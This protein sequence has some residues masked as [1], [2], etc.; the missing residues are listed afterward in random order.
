MYISCIDVLIWN[1]TPSA[2]YIL[3]V[4]CVK[5]GLPSLV[6]IVKRCILG[7]KHLSDDVLS[8]YIY[9]LSDANACTVLCERYC[10]ILILGG[11]TN[12]LI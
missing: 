2:K 4:E 1:G 9:R 5:I 3:F 8:N 11:Y 7:K 12:L 10:K 6:V